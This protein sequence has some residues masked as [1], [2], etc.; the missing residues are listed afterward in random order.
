MDNASF[1]DRLSRF[2][3]L[4]TSIGG[5]AART[6][7]E[8]TFGV[9]IDDEI[10]AQKLKENL[11]SLKGPLVKVAQFLATIPDAI[12]VEYANHLLEL[13]SNAPSMGVSFVRRRMQAE[14]GPNWLAK[15]QS[16]NMEASA[17]ASL[18]QVHR[19]Q[20]HDGTALA[21]KLQYPH[22]I[23]TVESD[24]SNFRLILG[25]YHTFNKALDT[26]EIQQ[27]IKDHLLEELDYENESSN[28]K[29]YQ[30]IFEHTDFVEVPQVFPELSTKRLITMNW[31]SGMP[32]LQNLEQPQEFREQV[33]HNLFHAWYLPFYHHGVIHG[34]P[35]LGNYLVQKNGAISLLDFGCIRYFSPNFVQAVVDLYKAFR[36]NQPDLAVHAY[37]Q[38]GFTNISKEMIDVMN[39]W[40]MLLYSPL[41]D[42]RV[43]PIQENFSGAQGW[44][45]ASKVHSELKRLG[46]IRPPRE[47][48]FMDRAAVGL[49]ASLMRLRVEMNWH[50]MFEKLIS[51]SS[52]LEVF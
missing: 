30:E 49:G 13:Q 18:G 7:G 4:S 22:M 38:W 26:A 5:L 17:A 39:H 8:K 19:A 40:A 48:V 37:K 6:I 46:G 50:Q 25:L 3:K 27:E 11:G 36:D 33:A 21:C 2:A 9:K 35:H 10:Y 14:L 1:V 41:L 42:D 23:D 52:F 43:R 15:F 12:P 24:L 32:L 31:L 47:F 29:R 28:I 34:D 51:N 44:E 20:H 45:T 16:F